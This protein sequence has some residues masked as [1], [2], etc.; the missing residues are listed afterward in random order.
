MTSLGSGK[1][2]SSSEN[3]AAAVATVLVCL[4]CI[5]APLALGGTHL[6]A[7]AGLNAGMAI[8]VCLW[9]ALLRPNRLQLAIPLVVCLVALLQLVPL[10]DSL[11]VWLAPISAGVWKVAH[12]GLPNAWGRISVDPAETAAA[13]RRGLLAMGTVGTI[14]SLSLRSIYRKWII[15]AMG[16]SGAT[17]WILG[18]LF[19]VQINSFILLGFVSFR[20]PLMPGRT[21]LEPPYATAAF[22][23]PE[24][25]QILGRQYHADSWIV[26]DGFG[27]YLITNHFAGALT[28]TIPMLAAAWLIVSR[29][30]LPAWLQGGVAGAIF[31]CAFATLAMLVQSR[32]GT[33]S[34]L[35]A[36]LAFGCF[37]AKAGTWRTIMVAATLAYVAVVIGFII[38]L[39][40]PFHGIGELFPAR[41][42]PAIT[43]L[44]SDGRVVASHVAE[45]MFLAS[46]ILGTGLGAYGDLYPRMVGDD[47]PWYFAHNEYAQ[48]LAETGIA[49]LLFLGVFFSLLV[50][51][52]TWFWRNAVGEDR[53]LGAAAWAALA[54]IVMHS[55]FDWNLRVPANAFLACA[56]T[57]LAL[58]AG[59]HRNQ[60]Q[61]RA[62]QTGA[63][64]GALAAAFIL[65]VLATAAFQARDVASEFVQRKLRE[66]ITS[67]RLYAVDP[68]SASP[69]QSLV[70]AI[71]AGERMTKWDPADAQLAASLGRAHLHRAAMPMPM[72]DVD[73][74]L[75]G[76][77]S[78]FQTA[79]RNCAVCRGIAKPQP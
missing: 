21:P 31:A 29:G 77:D 18:L 52:A 3:F 28:L 26:G 61:E 65:A 45:R 33:A 35:L 6:L 67:A 63:V 41:L 56:A 7:I 5:A 34:F 23:F 20:G 73:S 75:R 14:Y 39:F 43:A 9:A 71:E 78:W 12:E 50:R 17:I 30:R 59:S 58:A 10:P 27:P 53:I 62:A 49:G 38:I 44:L 16:L 64:R 13:A 55:F 57:G 48:L 79:R 60:Q 46:P 72:D 68:K 37:S 76:A 19:P 74:A 47:S 2:G 42:Q 25:V 8:V 51:S 32:A 66:A 15:A 11:L 36:V 24:P 1:A 40:G 4:G 70:S 54:G 69:E 22:G